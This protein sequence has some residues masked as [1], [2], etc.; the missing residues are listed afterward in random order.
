MRFLLCQTDLNRN[1]SPNWKKA[2]Q[3]EQTSSNFKKSKPYQRLIAEVLLP[4]SISIES[5]VSY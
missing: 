4:F 5:V 2:S 1:Q 3:F